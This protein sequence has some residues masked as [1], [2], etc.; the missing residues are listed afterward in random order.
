MSRAM[1]RYQYDRR[2]AAV[3]A[4]PACR[5]TYDQW[6]REDPAYAA[7]WLGMKATTHHSAMRGWL[8]MK[9]RDVERRRSKL[10]DRRAWKNEVQM[11]Y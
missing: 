1:N 6:I 2:K 9:D 4:C 3:L 7:K 11:S 5:E 8:S 10:R